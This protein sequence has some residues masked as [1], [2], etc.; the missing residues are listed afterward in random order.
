MPTRIVWVNKATWKKPGPIAYMG[1]LNAM[2]F[3]WQGQSTDFFISA[4]DDV[5]IAADLQNFYGL[6]PHPLLTI[7]PVISGRG[8]QRA[9]YTAALRTIERYCWE[10]QQVLVITRELGLLGALLRLRRRNPQLRV[11]HEV[12]DYYGSI[13]HQPKPGV[14]SVRRMLAE[15]CLLPRLDGLLCLT[16]YQRALYQ[17]WMPKLPMLVAPLGSAQPGQ[18]APTDLVVRQQRRRIAYIGHLHNYKGL[19]QILQLARALQHDGVEIHCYGG[20]QEQVERLT[21]QAQAQQL[22]HVLQFHAFVS[23]AALTRELESNISLGLVPLQDTY[24]SRY[25][26]CPVKALDFLKSGIPIV[27]SELP[28]VRDVVATAARLVAP[29]D[30]KAYRQQILRLLYDRDAYQSLAVEGFLRSRQLSW[31]GRAQSILDFDRSLRGVA[32]ETVWVPVTTSPLHS[33]GTAPQ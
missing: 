15:R 31:R 6:E 30:I 14:A 12:H 25:L 19:P 22:G 8:H 27:G 11:L 20:K 26:T 1:L 10:G 9:V 3:A 4:R 29:T 13:R 18:A 21:V 2:A 7:H 23:P 16:E 5:N 32:E 24:Y 28:C 17:Q 33:A